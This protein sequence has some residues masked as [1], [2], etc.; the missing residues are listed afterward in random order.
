MKYALK[1]IKYI[2]KKEVS[3]RRLLIYVGLA[4]LKLGDF[5]SAYKKTFWGEY[6][7][8][9]TISPSM[10]ECE[11]KL[12]NVIKQEDTNGKTIEITKII[13]NKFIT[14]KE[15]KRWKN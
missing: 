1:K 7:V 3:K 14:T 11:D 15:R 6:Y 2:I 13:V 5:Y 12:L 9:N 10:G 4:R 8:D